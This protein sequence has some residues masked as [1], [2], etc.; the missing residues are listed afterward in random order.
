MENR[1]VDHTVVT[2][3]T[4]QGHSVLELLHAFMRASARDIPYEILGRREGDVSTSYANVELASRYLNWT[5][6]RDL[7]RMC[8]DTWR[9]QTKNRTGY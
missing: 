6:E 5:A 1:P 3:G 8:V 7:D 2:I 4:G 9:W